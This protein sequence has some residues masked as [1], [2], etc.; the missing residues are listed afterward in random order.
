MASSQEHVQVLF[1]K[2]NDLGKE[3][4]YETALGVSEDILKV[5]PD[6]VDALHSKAVCLVHVGRFQPA[7][8]LLDR[9]V[10]QHKGR[11]DAFNM[12]RAYCVY[13]MGRY[14]ECLEMLKSLEGTSLERGAMEL[15]A[16]A[17][18]RLESYQDSSK[19]YERLIK[20]TKDDLVEERKANLLA[21]KA[22]SVQRG[23]VV[24]EGK[25]GKLTT[26]EQNFNSSL[27]ASGLGRMDRAKE[28]LN[29]AERMCR[30]VCVCVCVL[31]I[32]Y[33][34]TC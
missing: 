27:I 3:G 31:C 10:K 14:N 16:Q 22:L 13:R 17:L 21:S 23:E 20:E 5:F 6:D 19:T 34:Q 29:V 15:K 33:A 2:L 28:L 11:S 12:M 1:R 18:Y 26:Y 7:V 8:H 32:V 9:L 4:D 24:Q 25:F 30:E